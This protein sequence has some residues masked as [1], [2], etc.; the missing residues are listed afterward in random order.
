MRTPTG[1]ATA[2][3]LAL[4]A[5]GLLVSYRPQLIVASLGWEVSAAKSRSRGFAFADSYVDQRARRARDERIFRRASTF[6]TALSHF[7][8]SRVVAKR[9]RVRGAR[10]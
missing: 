8:M 6:F 9:P 3:L 7:H 10:M 1:P 2:C 4:R 5:L